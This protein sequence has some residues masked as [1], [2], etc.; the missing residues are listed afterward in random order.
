MTKT[1][2]DLVIAIIGGGLG[3]ICMAI[4][5]KQAGYRQ[6]TIFE[7]ADRPG[8]TWRDNTYPGLACDVP[9]HLYS[10]SFELNPEWSHT[11]APGWEIQQYTL[12]CADKYAVSSHLQVNSEVISCRYQNGQWTIHTADG[13][14]HQA[15]V[16][17][18]AMGGL[19]I[20]KFPDIPGRES[21]AGTAFHSARW[22]DISLKGKR[23]AV[24]GSAA[25]AVQIVPQ[26]AGVT[27][28]LSVFQRTPNWIIPR[29]DRAYS[30][31]SKWLFRTAPGLGRLYRW[32]LYGIAELRWPSF[33][34][35][36]VANK[37]GRW[38]G[39]AH[40]R[41][42]VPDKALRASLTPDYPIGCKRILRSDDFYPALLRDNV[43][44]ITGA[45]DHIDPHS[46]VTT[47]GRHHPADVIIYAT[48]F[49]VYDITGGTEIIGT[50]GRSLATEWQTG[51]AAHRTVALPGFPNFFMLQGP[52]SGLGHNS[53]IFM[54]EV[55]VRYVID[56]LQQMQLRQWQAVQ[57]RRQAY[58]AYNLSLNKNLKKMIWSGGCRSWYQDPTG[59]IF[60]LWPHTC[61]TY[62]FAMRQPDMDEY[63]EQKSE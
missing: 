35:G 6:I 33:R 37:L 44:L 20:A 40:L 38:L 45:I 42:Q 9:S 12:H 29:R 57:P 50:H 11:Y 13:K 25:S 15:D 8:G 62:W 4:K 63:E 48:G 41:N 5:L 23:V 19:H 56:L 52:N 26:I 31:L 18:S 60:T 1:S 54:L 16:L 39:V 59:K 27:D 46:I 43:E 2:N 55:Q 10:Y 51:I 21:F 30:K 17:I 14:V 47:D 7:K 49:D 22:Q 58:D 61:T 3:G 34:N 28:H 32:F 53:V 24:I 36:S